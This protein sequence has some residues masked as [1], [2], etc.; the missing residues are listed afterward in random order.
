LWETVVTYPE[1]PP[2]NDSG[3][4]PQPPSPPIFSHRLTAPPYVS[5]ESEYGDNPLVQLQKLLEPESQQILR[6]EV[7]SIPQWTAWPEQQHYVPVQ[8]GVAPWNVFPICHCFP[9]SDP[10]KLTWIEATCPWIPRTVQLLKQ[11]AGPALRTALFSRLDPNAVLEAHTGWADLANHVMRVH[12]PIQIPP[13]Q[14]C[15]V[16]VD[17]CV[18]T[19]SPDSLVVFDDSKIHRAFNYHPTQDRIVLIV[20]LERPAVLPVGTATGGH[21]E[22]L[23]A[24]IAQFAQPK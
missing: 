18:V 10:T 24:F 4:V 14:L 3:K 5:Y 8:N 22:E 11:N 20:D 6:H 2:P 17:G 23:D 19:H 15:G 13:H 9:A 16:W 1:P 12:V 21:S 7:A